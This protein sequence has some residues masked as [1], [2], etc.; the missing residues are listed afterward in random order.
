MSTP[1]RIVRAI[2]VLLDALHRAKLLRLD[3]RARRHRYAEPMRI[4]RRCW[5]ELDELWLL[6]SPVMRASARVAGD[7]LVA[8]NLGAGMGHCGVAGAHF[9]HRPHLLLL[10]Q[11]GVTG[12]MQ[13]TTTLKKIYR[14][15]N[16]H[17][18]QALE[19]I[20]RHSRLGAACDP[21]SP[22]VLHAKN[23]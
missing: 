14:R 12:A 10:P 3:M 7:L 21:S 16:L 9:L 13:R 18:F 6:A 1:W 2:G 20:L 15:A 4:V 8:T 22:Q 19:Q 17:T 5:A 23:L 11:R